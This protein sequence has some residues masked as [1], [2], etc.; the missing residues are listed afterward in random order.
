MADPRIKPIVIKTGVVTRLS[1]EKL[2]YE[3]EVVDQE[4]KIEKMKA[5]QKD[6]YDI[7]KQVEVLQE[8]KAMIPDCKRRLTTAHE[9]L[10]QLLEN[11]KDLCEVEQYKK[12]EL[13]LQN[14]LPQLS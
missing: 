6:E 11:E 5:D 9:E 7:K 12:A 3:K 4:A 2:M 10:K 13:A 14:S 1:K 8:S